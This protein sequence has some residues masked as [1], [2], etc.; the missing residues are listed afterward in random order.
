MKRVYGIFLRLYPREYRDLFGPEVLGVFAQAA[1]EQWARGW[2]VWACFMIS[3]LSGAVISAAGHWF[4]RF[5][6]W[7]HAPDPE[8]AGARRNGLFSVVEEA[9]ERVDFNLRRMKHAIAH[10]DFAAARAYSIEDLK[11]REE[12]RRLRDKYGF[13]DDEMALQ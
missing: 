5:A 8:S 1:E 13:G 2:T 6:A 3:E 12:L 9:E 7:R 11:A 10:H 4:D